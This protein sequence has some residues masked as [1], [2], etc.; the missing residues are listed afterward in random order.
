MEVC[1]IFGCVCFYCLVDKFMN[2]MKR[3]NRLTQDEFLLLKGT[4]K[5][6]TMISNKFKTYDFDVVE[7]LEENSLGQF[8][9]VRQDLDKSWLI[10][11]EHQEDIALVYSNF[12]PKE[13]EAPPVH[14]INIVDE[15]EQ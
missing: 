10:Y 6:A 15:F 3:F 5:L 9:V 7:W 12:T 11:F 8:C 2:I 1:T 13:P 4:E 14:K